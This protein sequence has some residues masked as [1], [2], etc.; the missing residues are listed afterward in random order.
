MAL[1]GSTLLGASGC[2]ALRDMRD[3]IVGVRPALERCFGN[4]DHVTP[5][6]LPIPHLAC[7]GG[8]PRVPTSTPPGRSAWP[9]DWLEES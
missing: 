7:R 4:R 1:L 3:E 5:A 8:T 6:W 9:T 2:S